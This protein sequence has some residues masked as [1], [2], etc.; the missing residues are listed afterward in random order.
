LKEKNSPQDL[1][2]EELQIVQEKKF[3]PRQQKEEIKQKYVD[4]RKLEQ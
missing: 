1:L 2:F 4:E 3:K